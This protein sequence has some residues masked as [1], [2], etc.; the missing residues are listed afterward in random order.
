MFLV[1]QLRDPRQQEIMRKLTR[2]GKRDFAKNL[3]IVARTLGGL[4]KEAE[5]TEGLYSSI[6]EQIDSV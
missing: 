2:L 5:A 3:L 4:M 6:V 1:E